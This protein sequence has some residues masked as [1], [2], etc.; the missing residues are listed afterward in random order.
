[1]VACL[2]AT[3]DTGFSREISVAGLRR[4]RTRPRHRGTTPASSTSCSTPR[5]RCRARR[6]VGPSARRP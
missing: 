5:A 2:R 4:R 6:A 1:V 3:T